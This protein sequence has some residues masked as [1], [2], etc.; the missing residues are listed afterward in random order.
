MGNSKKNI[1]KII[2]IVFLLFAT[3]FTSYAVCVNV[4]FDSEKALGDLIGSEVNG[5]GQ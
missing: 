3:L 2:K 5:V 4:S 1:S